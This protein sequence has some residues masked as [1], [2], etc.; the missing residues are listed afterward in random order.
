MINHANKLRDRYSF[1]YF[2]RSWWQK[3]LDSM[4]AW[5]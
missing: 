2:H 3:F 4:K 1:G 5:P